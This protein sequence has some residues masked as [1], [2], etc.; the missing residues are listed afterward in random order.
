[1]EGSKMRNGDF[2]QERIWK[3]EDMLSYHLGQLSEPYRSTVH[4]IRFMQS[5]LSK[6]EGEA[7]DVACGTGANIVHM[8]QVFRGY[9]WTGLDYDGERLFPIGHQYVE[10]H[11]PEL[12]IDY[13]IGD[14]YR[15]TDIFTTKKFDL[16]IS[17][18]TLSFLPEYERAV[19]QLLAVTRGWVF[20]S[21]MFSGFDIDAK[22]EVIDHTRAD[23]LRVPQ[24]YNV[25]SLDRFQS[26]CEKLGCRDFVSRDFEID[27][28]IPQKTKGRGTYTQ[29]LA[30]GRRLQFSGPLHMPW[31]FIGIRMG[32]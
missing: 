19:E 12:Q 1:M 2:N 26:F 16:T 3:S 8:A 7:L 22:R 15:L 6:P 14:M 28:D 25:Y 18:Q 21:S 31:K 5:I 11:H 23:G 24:Y 32:D 27:I 13:V 29:T 10:K 17:I 20:V 30:D 9:R 4:F